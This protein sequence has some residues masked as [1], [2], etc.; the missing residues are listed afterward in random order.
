MTVETVEES[1]NDNRADLLA[2]LTRLKEE[3]RDLDSA[4]DA[5]E[6]NVVADQL[7]IQRLKKRKLTLRDRISYV[8]DQITPDIIA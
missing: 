6:R 7:Q 5:L 3:H 8:E 1:Q 4:I 2:E